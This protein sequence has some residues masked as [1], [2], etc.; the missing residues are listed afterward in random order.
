MKTKTPGPG[1]PRHTVCPAQ[2]APCPPSQD[3]ES[4]GGGGSLL[5]LSSH[6]PRENLP[7]SQCTQHLTPH[8]LPIHPMASPSQSTAAEHAAHHRHIIS[9]IPLHLPATAWNQA[10]KSIQRLSS[11]S[12]PHRALVLGPHGQA[13]ELPPGT[14]C[15]RKLRHPHVF[16]RSLPSPNPSRV[17]SQPWC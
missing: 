7:T 4:L 15:H 12:P 17:P 13:T 14:A 9:R 5:Y 11:A 8:L 16:L 3:T 2:M 1:L 10:P 6:S